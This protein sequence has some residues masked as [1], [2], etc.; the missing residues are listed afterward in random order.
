MRTVP[1]GSYLIN[2]ELGENYI[3]VSQA[4]SLT[5]YFTKIKLRIFIIKTYLIDMLEIILDIHNNWMD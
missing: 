2:E 5:N 1:N 4:T 3:G